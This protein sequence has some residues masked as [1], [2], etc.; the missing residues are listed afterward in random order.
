MPN[1]GDVEYWNERYNDDNDRPFDWLF[2]FRELQGIITYLV[3]D[4][5]EQIFLVGA[6][7]APFSP[8]LSSIGS[9][10][11][12]FNTDISSVVIEKQSKLFP[13]QRWEVMDATDLKLSDKSVPIVIDKSLI[14]TLLCCSQSESKYKRMFSEIHRI[15]APGAR[16]ISFSLHPIN[17]VQNLYQAPELYSWKASFYHVRSNRWNPKKNLKRA[18]SHTLIVCDMPSA[19]GRFERLPPSDNMVM[20]GL[21]LSDLE[22]Q[23]L[24]DSAQ[25]YLFKHALK[26]ATDET[27]LY[28]FYNALSEY[29]DNCLNVEEP[30]DD[31]NKLL[32][33]MKASFAKWKKKMAP[34][35]D[36]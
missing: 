3:P 24:K 22:D 19:S 17:E 26:H 30:T 8:E 25:P 6:G 31:E 35:A 15:M 34:R 16:F 28:C 11:N 2:D 29:A 32:K 36:K 21:I 10:T 12:V 13:E 14:D 4:R 23:Q 9:Y 20:P 1:Y 18:T 33:R 7:N 27:L 5:T